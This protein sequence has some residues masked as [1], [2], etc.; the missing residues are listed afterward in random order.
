MKW[1]L[2]LIFVASSATAM[3]TQQKEGKA[4]SLF[5]VVTFPNK[6][7]TTQ[8]N[9]MKGICVTAEECQNTG[10]TVALASGNCASG[11]GVC[12]LRT[13]ETSGTVTEDLT[14]IQSVG[15]P[16]PVAALNAVPAVDAP[17]L[18]WNIMTDPS[19]CAV[20]FD[21]LSAQLNDPANGVCAD[22]LTVTTSTKNPANGFVPGN[23]CGVL[24]GQHMF[25]D[26]SSTG[27]ATAA[28]LTIDTAA[29][30]GDRSWQILV[31]R[32]E[33][34]SEDLP[35]AGCLQYFTGLSGQITSFNGARTG[36]AQMMLQNQ[37]YRI[38]I[39][40]APGMCGVT[41]REAGGAID[42]FGLGIVNA[43]PAVA[44]NVGGPTTINACTVQWLEIQP[45]G[46][47]CGGFFGPI[48]AQTTA[49]P[50]TSNEFD[51]N[52]I[53]NNGASQPASGFNL[54]YNQRA[55]VSALLP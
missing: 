47:I 31:R 18:A 46:E 10:N 36:N 4:F 49:G 6:E 2:C 14:H 37:N 24:T 7:C 28:T 29:A 35:P 45:I 32:I 13:I 21:I 34:S 15:F 42:S 38:C 12:C 16:T 3:H 51:I 25:V 22:T 48:N 9:E 40:K 26:V 52:V 44:D 39:K 8:T 33:C 1:T 11:F 27:G 23:L 20:K 5:S 30:V 55:C 54:I 43:N 19:C 17:A 50:V 53:T 41:Y